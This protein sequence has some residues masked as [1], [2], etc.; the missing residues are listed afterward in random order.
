MK[1]LMN[2][3]MVELMSQAKWKNQYR[4]LNKGKIEFVRYMLIVYVDC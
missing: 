1:T 3:A 4:N 2:L